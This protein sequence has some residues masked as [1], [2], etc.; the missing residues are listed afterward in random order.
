M[1]VTVQQNEDADSA[2]ESSYDR[3]TPNHDEPQ[4]LSHEPRHRLIDRDQSKIAGY[5]PSGFALVAITLGVGS[6]FAWTVFASIYQHWILDFG[7]FKNLRLTW[8]IWYV[9]TA[10]TVNVMGT[11]NVKLS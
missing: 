10:K 11:I 7:P 2:D 8:T 5:S 1:T 6:V 9:L 3:L 4:L